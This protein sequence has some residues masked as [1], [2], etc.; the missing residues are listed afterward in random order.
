[1]RAHYATCKEIRLLAFG[2][3]EG[4][5]VGIYDLS[6]RAWEM[7]RGVFSTLAEAK[8]HAQGLAAVRNGKD[9]AQLKWH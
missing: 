6:R 1:M 7:E 5:H 9:L 3:P 4:W 8:A 2:L